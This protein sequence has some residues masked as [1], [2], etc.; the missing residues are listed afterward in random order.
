MAK[1]SSGKIKN[2]K[3]KTKVGKL[4]VAILGMACR[5]PD[6]KN[7]HEFWNNLENGKNAIREITPDRWDIEKYYST[8]PNEPDKSLSK[9][10]GLVDGID[11]F[12]N[13]FFNISPRE[14]ANMDPQQRILLE[15][16]WHCIEDSGIPLNELRKRKTSVFVGVMAVDY[17]QEVLRQGIDTD[18]FA[19]LGG[20]EC[21]LAN[22]V[23]YY[24]DFNGK[25]VSVNAACASTIVAINDAKIS[26]DKGECDYAL[27]AGVNLNI[28]PWKYIS[29]SK[30]RMLSP[31]GQCKT[32]DSNA[33]GYVPGDGIGVFLLSRLDDAQKLNCSIY[34]VVK[35]SAVN[36]GGRT[37]SITAPRIEAQRDV[38]V[39]AYE[40]SGINPDTVTYIEAHGTGTSLGDPIEVEALTQAFSK[41]THRKQFCRI[42]SVKSNIGHL[43]A[44][45]GA[46]SL[47]KVLMMMKKR[48][49]P[50]TINLSTVNPIIDFGSSPFIPAEK[51]VQWEQKDTDLPV[52]AGISSFGFG[53]VNSHVVIEEYPEKSEVYKSDENGYIFTLSAKTISAFGTLVEEWSDFVRNTDETEFN[54][55]DICLTQLTGREGLTFRAGSIISEKAQLVE[56]LK[57]IKNDGI[58]AEQRAPWILFLGNEILE[59]FPERL[60]N[61]AE[62]ELFND[63][64]KET[65]D[66]IDNKKYSL[67][68]N[69]GIKYAAYEASEKKVLSFILNYTFIKLYLE[70]GFKPEII[71][72]IGNGHILAMTLSGIISLNDAVSFIEGKMETTDIKLQRPVL[73]YMDSLTGK[74]IKPVEFNR[75]YLE[76][77]LS[78][79]CKTG[80]LNKGIVE[81]A[82]ILLKNQYTFKKYMEEWEYE[83]GKQSIGSLMEALWDDSI[84]YEGYEY[85]ALKD[86]VI[87]AIA[88]SLKK[89]NL[90]WKL[91]EKREGRS[92]EFFELVDLVC[93][94]VISKEMLIGMVSAQNTNLDTIISAMEERHELIDWTNP[95]K[96]LKEKSILSGVDI[97]TWLQQRDFNNIPE[98]IEKYN[99]YCFGTANIKGIKTNIHTCIK[100]EDYFNEFKKCLMDFWCNGVD[101]DWSKLYRDGTFKKVRLPLNPFEGRP[102]WIYDKTV[103]NFSTSCKSSV[104]PDNEQYKSL[105]YNSKNPEIRDHVILG[106][107]IVPAAG[108]II[109]VSNAIRKKSAASELL[110]FRIM[111]KAPLVMDGYEEFLVE[112]FIDGQSFD[113]KFNDKQ[114]LTGNWTSNINRETLGIHVIDDKNLEVTL[115]REQIYRILASKGYQYG[116]AFKAISYGG[117]G[118]SED[119]V[120]KFYIDNE[121]SPDRSFPGTIIMDGLFQAALVSAYS[122]GLVSEADH[123]YIPYFI[124][125]I[126]WSASSTLNNVF[127]AV[128]RKNDMTMR[129]GDLYASISGCDASGKELIKVCDMVFKCVPRD[130]LNKY[131]END[132]EDKRDSGIYSY[133]FELKE[134]ALILGAETYSKRNAVIFSEED[135]VA[136]ALVSEAVNKYNNVV[137]VM[138]G[139]DFY[140]ER[141]RVI[142]LNPYKEEDYKRLITELKSMAGESDN[143]Y[144]LFYLWSSSMADPFT[145]MGERLEEAFVEEVQGI[146]YLLKHWGKLRMALESRLVI[147]AKERQSNTGYDT[148]A[149]VVKSGIL[150]F[151]RSAV[152]EISKLTFRFVDISKNDYQAKLIVPTL[153]KE[154]N[155]LGQE[156]LV[157]YRNGKRYTGIAVPMGSYS[158]SGIFSTK[159]QGA[160]L[161][162]GGAGEIGIKLASELAG[163]SGA[164]VIMLGRSSLSDEKADIIKSVKRNGLNM[165]YISCDITDYEQAREVIAGV[166]NTYGRINGVI[167]AAGVIDDGLLAGKSMQAL[168][169]VVRPKVLGAFYLHLLTKEQPLEFF[170]MFSS[171]VSITGNA[172]QT[173]YSAANAFMDAFAHYRAANGFSGKSLSINWCLWK[174]GGMGLSEKHKRIFERKTGTIT[175]WQAIEKLWDILNSDTVQ[176]IVT[177]D[178][179]TFEKTMAGKLFTSIEEGR[180]GGLKT[181]EIQ[182][183]LTGMLSDILQIPESEMDYNTDIREFGLESVSLNELAERIS[184]FFGINT[185]AALF[186]EYSDIKQLSEYIYEKQKEL[187]VKG[188]TVEI[189]TKK[190]IPLLN[191]N[192][193]TKILNMPLNMEN[194][195]VKLNKVLIHL[196][197]KVL[198]ISEEELDEETDLRDFGMESVSLSDYCNMINNV[199]G[200]DIDASLIFE[201]SDIKGITQ[202][203]IDK[204][205]QN[206]LNYLEKQYGDR[207]ELQTHEGKKAVLTYEN[208]K[209]ADNCC[210]NGYR[211]GD[212]AIIG[213]SGRFPGAEDTDEFWKNIEGNR[214]M[215]TEIP[216][217]RWNWMEVF[218]DS[219][220]TEDKTDVKWGGFLK[221]IRTFDAS[222]FKISRREA[223]LMDPQQRIMLEEAWHAVEDAGLKPSALAG[224]RTGVF[225]GVV[226]TDYDELLI[227][228]GNRL[229]AHTSTGLYFSVIPNRI[230]YFMDLKGASLAM[231]TACSSSLVA[232]HEAVKA[233]QV[234]ECEMALAGGV[235]II[236]T[237]RRYFSFSNAGMLSKDGRC[238]TFDERA[239]GYVRGEG[240]GIVLLKPLKKAVEDGDDIY[241]VIK[242]SAVNHGGFVGTLTKPNPNAQA[243]LIVSAYKKAGIEPDTVTFIE[244]H[245][246]GTNL[247][248]PIEINGL[249]KAFEELY[250]H[251]GKKISKTAYCGIGAVKTNIGHLESAAG[252]A[253]LIKLIKAMRKGVIPANVNYIKQN[254]HIKLDGSPFYL[255]AENRNWQRMKD[256]SGSEIP[257]RCGVSSFGFG[258]VNAHIVLEEFNKDAEI[259]AGRVENAVIVLSAKNHESLKKYAADMAKAFE[260]KMGNKSFLDAV[261]TLQ[262]GREAFEER[263][264]F[265][266]KDFITAA[267]LLKEYANDNA[268]SKIHKGYVKKK[269]GDAGLNTGKSGIKVNAPDSDGKDADELAR[270]WVS[271]VE[272]DWDG[273]YKLKKRRV[274]LPG[275]PFENE[276]YW[277]PEQQYKSDKPI[278]GGQEETICDKDDKLPDYNSQSSLDDAKLLELLKK[279][280][281]GQLKSK[282]VKKLMEV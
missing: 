282:D 140:F 263:L 8:N 64:L 52:R 261:Y 73:P 230:S 66:S 245:G 268:S 197:S 28:H 186:F 21:I 187:E 169:T 151:V 280:E 239:D 13:R 231:D 82:R 111:V 262:T 29:F 45:A 84:F 249:K 184:E 191:E 102:F 210:M 144:D 71:S 116:Q 50:P 227:R 106:D 72:G 51:L 192:G 250:R 33:D 131:K 88:C 22:R 223:E 238:K 149:G 163:R 39:A 54:L 171:I 20:Y 220:G 95:Y 196:L 157:A 181:E 130:F 256:E 208:K 200:T 232:I 215:I 122:E 133:R 164:Q 76:I 216:G 100:N 225:I 81:K 234:G 266:A 101:I 259:E 193:G 10:C 68:I 25:S 37:S 251:S 32:F 152:I 109:G 108:M 124:G 17:R 271:G 117:L 125:K 165:E 206:I 58:K 185:D 228:N 142:R 40:D 139:N 176:C 103:A 137:T 57:N 189:E 178:S 212:I 63:K 1:Q 153:F 120:F 4:E 127:Y 141:D 15:E 265:V 61:S 183:E 235:N 173:D 113:L 247:G 14:A 16:T 112:P 203:L 56:F 159:G 47:V 91:K 222:F 241:A 190:S 258:G 244:A 213:I 19:C 267:E 48:M 70:M 104:I 138:K 41:Y 110:M 154:I 194:I 272:I 205:R 201:Y 269:R 160:Y 74:V 129:G 195:A 49:I 105:S 85:K 118:F 279:L 53:G 177:G 237:P 246:T 35:G 179:S 23:S 42:G 275:Y 226:N 236:I 67:L 221:D 182:L 270:L 219:S 155:Q 145:N 27:V 281:N 55:K 99:V 18:S 207:N 167:H 260:E 2:E 248:D 255:A 146:F 233:I 172:G 243:E 114:I 278:S 168:M 123:I 89:L 6:A 188:K 277:L 252:I 36:H 218:G 43:E 242:G 9:W 161:I 87:I 180:E 30:S 273:L 175:S 26:L 128:I 11:K 98:Y 211:E 38:I 44:A 158:D 86:I 217:D 107:V 94:D 166:V 170:V 202:Y 198:T 80:D 75:K 115:E 31:N 229:D 257:R 150:G 65:A 69:Q 135:S 136:N 93:D 5:F 90:K 174:D 7:Y 12:D 60:K 276:E 199:L 126:I 143:G 34:G 224:T 240:A 134:K 59:F 77:L 253:G 254:P 204:F 97:E 62:T 24:F 274:H 79:L 3:K 92:R 46:A 264:A 83:A 148:G 156:D 96:Q 147:L 214:D 119:R 132:F 209:Q 162:T 78:C 121:A